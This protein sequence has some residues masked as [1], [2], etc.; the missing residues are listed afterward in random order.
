MDRLHFGECYPDLQVKPWGFYYLSSWGTNL[1]QVDTE[2]STS[3]LPEARVCAGSKLMGSRRKQP[4]LWSGDETFEGQ[5]AL[6]L[7][8]ESYRRELVKLRLSRVQKSEQL[9]FS[10]WF[11]T[12]V[13]QHMDMVLTFTISTKLVIWSGG[14]RVVYYRLWRFMIKIFE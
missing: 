8:N 3:Q 6:L 7:Q 12:G 4:G 14:V 1:K 11:N 2:T 13:R 10:N 5:V 9:S